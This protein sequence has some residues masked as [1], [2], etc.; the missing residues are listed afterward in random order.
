MAWPWYL[1]AVGYIP[2]R[3][4]L[5]AENLAWGTGSA[6]SP[7]AIFRAWL[8]SPEHRHNVL[9]DYSQ[10]GLGLRIGELGGRSDVAVWTE[11]FGSHCNA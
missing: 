6:G 4:W 7:G 2:A 1:F 8:H 10:T 3:C 9:G 5:V 11:H